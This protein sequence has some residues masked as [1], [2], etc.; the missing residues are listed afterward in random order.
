MVVTKE[1][2]ID[3]S[4]GC[5]QLNRSVGNVVPGD[6]VTVMY[7]GWYINQSTGKRK[8]FE[9]MFHSEKKL[10]F[11]VNKKGQQQEGVYPGLMEGVQLMVL[12]EKA[13]L[14]I[15]AAD[16]FGPN[17]HRGFIGKVPPNSDLVVELA[18]MS[19][20]RNTVVHYRK[21]PMDNASCLTKILYFFCRGY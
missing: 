10:T 19:V 17:E 21:D 8:E 16:G 18:I 14:L 2:I 11:K 20:A 6:R 12:G 3:E 7:Q 5:D 4:D 9:D 15:P 1:S 13:R